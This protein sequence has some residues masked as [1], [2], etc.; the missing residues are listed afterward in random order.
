MPVCLRDFSL[1]IKEYTLLPVREK[2][3]S[4]AE[5]M[6]KALRF[7]P[8]LGFL[9]GFFI[10][11]WMDCLR[12]IP[13]FSAAA[14]LLGLEML[15]G[16]M[17]MMRGFMNLVDG[18]RISDGTEKDKTEKT[19]YIG[20]DVTERQRRFNVGKAGLVA[21]L[22]RMIAQYYIYLFFLRDPSLGQFSII[23]AAVVARLFMV[24]AVWH[25]PAVYPGRL[26]KGVG[27]REFIIAC[28]PAALV[29]IPFSSPILLMSLLISFLG[30]YAF[31][32]VRVRFCMA[33]DES[34][35]S[36]IVLCSE[37]LFL[38]SWLAVSQLL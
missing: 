15:L 7:L 27:K 1:L 14:V 18:I 36:T 4:P 33:L 3:C 12:V 8:L 34:C 24:W 26:H 37:L 13:I 19:G 21:G 31:A 25:F 35:Y 11:L 38:L 17:Y 22:L 29:L 28:I 2:W 23:L 32:I 6:P 9:S 16:G 20:Q 30:I 5:R 10:Y